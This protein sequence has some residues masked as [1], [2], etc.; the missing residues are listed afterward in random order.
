MLTNYLVDKFADICITIDYVIFKY[1]DYYIINGITEIFD[2][3]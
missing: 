1:D 3:R 2:S